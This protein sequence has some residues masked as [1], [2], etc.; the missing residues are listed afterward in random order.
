MIKTMVKTIE[1]LSKQIE[2]YNFSLNN[3]KLTSTEQD[4]TF[5]EIDH[6]VEIINLIKLL[7]KDI[8]G[9]NQDLKALDTLQGENINELSKTCYKELLNAKKDYI[10]QLTSIIMEIING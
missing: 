3:H 6:L 2:Y 8:E 9:V 7:N 4:L 1:K 10:L 5:K